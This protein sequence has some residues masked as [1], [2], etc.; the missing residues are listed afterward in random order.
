MVISMSTSRTTI[1]IDERSRGLVIGIVCHG[2]VT[3]DDYKKLLRPKFL[4]TIEY[5]SLRLVFLMR[6]DFKGW[7]NFYSFLE[8]MWT[9][10]HVR[11]HLQR[12]ATVAHPSRLAWLADHSSLFIKGEARLYGPSEKRESMGVGFRGPRW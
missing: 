10:L 5:H 8:D 7:S 4:A 3:A 2:E 11:K 6:D 1:T 12:V 9:M